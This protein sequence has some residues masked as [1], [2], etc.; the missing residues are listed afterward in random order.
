VLDELTVRVLPLGAN[1]RIT[2][3][4]EIIDEYEREGGFQVSGF[5]LQVQHQNEQ[6]IIVLAPI[7]GSGILDCLP[8][9]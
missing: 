1:N 9:N 8:K 6:D 3:P 2:I 4:K 7:Y 5:K